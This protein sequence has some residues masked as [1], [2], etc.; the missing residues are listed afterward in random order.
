MPTVQFQV[1]LE[2]VEL[3]QTQINQIQKE[4]NTAVAGILAKQGAAKQIWGSKLK[5]SP[6]WYGKW[7][8]QFKDLASLKA[9][10][11]FKQERIG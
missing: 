8:R 11:N 6:D 5:L 7:L 4:I 3:S 2:N 10:E 9:N 1:K